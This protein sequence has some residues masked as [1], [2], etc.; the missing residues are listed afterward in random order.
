MTVYFIQLILILFIGFFT[1][2]KKPKDRKLNM[3][4]ITTFLIL[5]VV[6]GLRDYSV[7]YDSAQ[8]RIAFLKTRDLS[9]GNLGLLRYEYGF[10]FL[11]KCLNLLTN[12]WQILFLVTSIFINYCVLR[13]IKKNSDNPLL[14]VLMYVLMNFYF[15]YISAMRQALAISIVLL[16]Y[17]YLKSDKFIKFLIFVGIACLF[18]GSAILAILFIPIKKIK[19]SKNF[20]P[21]LCIILVVSFFFG[22]DIFAILARF[23]SRLSDYAS[24]KFYAENYFGALLQFILNFILYV[25]GLMVLFK[26]GKTSLDDKNDTLSPLVGILAVANIFLVLTMKVSIFNRFSPFFSVFIIIWI[27]N[28]IKRIPKGKDRFFINIGLVSVLTLYWLI[29]NILRPEWYGVNPF[30]FFS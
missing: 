17:E 18:H 3:F 20:L 10:T 2:Y 22:R 24:S 5:T 11:C 21:I 15:F 28:I 25:F 29:I 14:S 13:F 1:F 12:N 9:F 7:G 16:G 30:K 4:F 8:Y 19:Y 26:K 27:P 23:S 6:A